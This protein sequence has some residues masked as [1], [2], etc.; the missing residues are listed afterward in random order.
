MK[1]DNMNDIL[2]GYTEYEGK[3]G[4]F[5]AKAGLRYEYTWQ[6][7]D[8]ELGHGENFKKHYG[9]LVPSASL[10]YKPMPIANIGLTYNMRI[11]R[12]GIGYLNPYV[13]RSSTTAISYGNPDLDVEK[14]HNIGLV[15]NIYTPVIMGNLN[16]K[17]AITNNG[18]EQYS[19]WKDGLL[20]TT[21]DNI[22]KRSMTTVSLYAA[23]M[24]S[25]KTRLFFNGGIGYNDLRS[26]Q[27]DTKNHGWQANAMVG[28]QQTLP[29]DLKLG[30]FF[31]T[32]SKKYTLQ[33]WTSGFNMVMGSLTKSFFNDKLNV[34]IQGV[35]GLRKGGR[36]YFDSYSEGKDF[37]N[38]QRIHV[39]VASFTFNITYNFGNQK[40]K[41]KQNT[42]HVESDVMEKQSDMNQMN[43][44]NMGQ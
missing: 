37:T 11:S 21:Y 6:D 14:T 38:M 41:V 43:N 4:K 42:K 31:I 1:Y 2:A 18:I 17:Q 7:V 5:G 25:K 16:I 15:F 8:F 3:Y 27:L 9:N 24:L 23:G 19:F 13:D 35:T 44:M 36:F 40:V 28:L 32:N 39:P 20:N 30:A 34:A 12:P 33:G 26:K 10:S 22:V 29:W